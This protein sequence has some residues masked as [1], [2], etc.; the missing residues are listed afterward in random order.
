ML[1]YFFFMWGIFFL[2]FLALIWIVFAVFQDIKTREIANWLNFSLIIFALGFR[3]FYSLFSQGNGGGF[4]FFYQGL[5]GLGIFFA[6]GHIFYYSRIFAGGDAKMMISLGAV[7][8]FYESFFANLKIFAWFLALFLFAG[9][10]YG[11]A[12]G[13]ALSL[14]NWKKFKKEFK[15]IF[16]EKRKIVYYVMFLGLFVSLLGIILSGFAGQILLFEGFLV[17]ILPYFYL[18][19][20]AVD[21]TC[22]IK[23]IKTGKLREGDWLYKNLRIGKKIIKA[24]WDGL[25]EK[26]IREIRR[27]CKEVKIRQGIPFTPVFLFSFLALIILFKIV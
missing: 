8:P 5:I 27:N 16:V 2:F 17:F 24:R 13:M 21:E 22:M 26:E 10:F 18:Y 20:K 6:L 23:K 11:F 25:N 1:V 4:A 7:L 14:K 12:W 15:R 19:A 9:A 3:F